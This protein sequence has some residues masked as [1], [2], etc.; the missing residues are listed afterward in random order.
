MYAD[1]FDRLFDR[2][3]EAVLAG[4]HYRDTPPVDGGRWGISVVLLPDSD[5]AERLDATTAAALSVAG[6]HWPTG[7]RRSL[8]VTVRALEAHRSHLPDD[9]PGVAR[10]RAAMRAAAA[11]CR[12]AR[13]AFRGLTLTPSGVMACAFPVDAAADEFAVALGDALGPDGWFEADVTRDIWYATIVHF[14]GPIADPSALVD[15]V[16]A[17]RDLDL[18]TAHC[19]QATLLRWCHTGTHLAP[20]PLGTAPFAVPASRPGRC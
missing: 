10:Y 5:C 1:S 4:S 15:W 8:H 9:D 14:T 18:G 19:A 11:G 12:P 16:A 13:L 7:A 2:G 17:R 3:R 20:T 6:T